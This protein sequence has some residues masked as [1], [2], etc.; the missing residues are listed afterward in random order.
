MTDGIAKRTT[1]A[2]SSFWRF[3]TAT[4]VSGVGS[5]VTLVALPLV[6]VTVL[7]A[8]VIQVSLLAA[9]G[10]I[11]WLILGLPAGVIVQRYPLRRLQVITDLIRLVALASVPVAWWLGHLTYTHL[12][13]AALV[14]GLATVVF[15]VG[16]ATFLPA[17][18]DKK[19]LTARNG[20]M[21]GTLSVT[22]TGGPSLG[23]LL[24]QVSGPVGA[25]CVDAVSYLVSALTLRS[26]PEVPRS[27]TGASPGRAR[28]TQQIREGWDFVARHPVMMPCMWWATAT[29]FA[30]GSLVALTPTYL[31]REAHLSP[32]MV[33]LLVAADGIGS[34]VGSLVAARLATRFGTARIMIL[35]SLVGAVLA[36]A[37][38]LTVGLGSALFFAVGNAGYGAGVVIGSIVTR[39]H[40][41]TESPPELLSRVMATVRFVS[42]GALPL[43][44][45]LS[46]LLAATAGLR[47]ALWLLCACTFLG[48]AILLLSGVRGR[49][50]LSE[51]VADPQTGSSAAAA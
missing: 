26:L 5:A 29:N 49:R 27:S 20:L 12:V 1:E 42:W 3:W 6:A 8:S 16:N 46:G 9:A 48:P 18:I 44:A 23:G 15:D 19:D 40:R 36:T 2:S 14:V 37:M 24:V 31:V 43:G 45:A 39:T 17:I 28:F 35:A 7:D 25:L 4:T 13:V 33:G 22:Q 11:G 30:V 34:L 51:K 21:S 10:Q 32:L 50:D 41:Q 38:P 47:P